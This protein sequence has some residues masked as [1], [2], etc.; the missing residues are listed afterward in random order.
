MHSRHAPAPRCRLQRLSESRRTIGVVRHPELIRTRCDELPLH[1][2]QGSFILRS[3]DRGSYLA[4]TDRS[5][6]AQGAHEA[7]HGA[8][9][10]LEAVTLQLVPDLPYTVDLVVVLPDPADLFLK[11]IIVALSR[12]DTEVIILS[13]LLLVLGRRSDRQH[14]AD[15]LDSVLLA[16]VVDELCHRFGWRTSSAWA[17]Y[18]LAFRKISFARLSSRFSRS[19]SFIRCRSSLVMPAR[20]P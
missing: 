18:A 4:S 13:S 14:A 16:V 6:E 8:P 19:S 12:W 1:Q 17:K 5:L 10:D 20:R 15:R 2:I 3:G 11:D 7:L 9:G